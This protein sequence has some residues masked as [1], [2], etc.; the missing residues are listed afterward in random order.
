MLKKFLSITLTT[1]LFLSTSM[2]VASNN[3]HD[4]TSTWN[5]SIDQAENSSQEKIYVTPD[6]IEITEDGILYY[7]NAEE[8]VMLANAL[9]YDTKGLYLRPISVERGPCNI[10][11]DWYKF[12][13]GCGVLYC[14]MKCAC[15]FGGGG[16]Q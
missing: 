13:G 14:P 9:F 1:F 10:H 7:D 3:Q 2:L 12:C 4:G 11:N 16:D 5:I 15:P 8:R 6:L